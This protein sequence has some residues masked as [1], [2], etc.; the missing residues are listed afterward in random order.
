MNGGMNGNEGKRGM[1]TKG[2][3]GNEYECGNV[4]HRPDSR[5]PAPKQSTRLS[6]CGK[7]TSILFSSPPHPWPETRPPLILSPTD[8]LMLK[9][10]S[11]N[12][13]EKKDLL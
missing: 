5:R 1:E 6:V 10:I 12:L 7:S 9:S 8:S 11:M 3:W 4:D 2:K 13:K